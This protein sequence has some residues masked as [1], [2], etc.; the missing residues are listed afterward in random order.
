[1]ETTD[2]PQTR[3][4]YY[5]GLFITFGVI[6]AF[7]TSIV[8]YHLEMGSMRAKLDRQAEEIFEEK[9]LEL[10]KFF[11]GL[12]YI[13][14]AL[15]GSQLLV[16]YINSPN[17]ETYK[18]AVDLFKGVTLSNPGLMQARYLD[19]GGQERIRIDWVFGTERPVVIAEK[20]LQQ[21][22]HRYYF[23]EASK[24]LPQSFWYS[25]LDLNVENRII[26]V[27]YK[28]VLRIA[29]PI[30]VAQKFE[31][32][33]VINMH[34]KE[35]LNKLI[36]DPVFDI[37]LID[38]DGY[39]MRSHE[40]NRSWSRYLETGYTVEKMKP[41]IYKEILY[42]DHGVQLTRIGDLYI[43]SVNKFLES[44][45]ALLL[46][47]GKK[48]KMQSMQNERQKAAVLI[49]GVI[50][51]L[52]I[53]LA[54]LISKRPADMHRRIT[55]QN[56]ILTESMLLIDQNIHTGIMDNKG[57]FV[58]VSSAFAHTLGFPKEQFPGMP[59]QKIYAKN[60]P[61]EE[62]SEIWE[63]V[64]QGH[65]WS[66]E[67]QH[68]KKNGDSY[69]ADAVLVPKRDEANHV[70][71]VTVLFQ[72]ITDKKNIELLSN[73]DVM[74]G[75][76]NR[77]FFSTTIEKELRRAFRDSKSLSFAMLDVD[78]FKNYNDNYG[79]Q[80][81]DYVLREVAKVLESKMARGSDYCFRLGGEEF[82]LLFSDISPEDALRFVDKIRQAIFDQNIEHKWSAAADVVTVSIGLL[83]IIPSK[84]ASVDLI[85]RMA[86]EVLYVAKG[87]GKNCVVSKVYEGAA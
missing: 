38:G 26:E 57:L 63:T 22:G 24:I 82:G 55:N 40:E 50:F 37:C 9:L 86:D 73:T 23:T 48:D 8:N 1:M 10:G 7:C 11:G 65:T 81:G 75:L 29:T 15:S 4:L 14:T 39:F 77:R 45:R 69:W 52:S 28:P 62:Y 32:I 41:D 66:G 16:E 6:I 12:D 76:Y 61:Q 68:K 79:H 42:R 78:F 44:D 43:G 19:A 46:M 71:G 18:R 3:R 17:Q 70:S 20:E 31:G 85:Y 83:T 54:L 58:E 64:L 13:V 25:K 36:H 33:I 5:V 72:D 56:Q 30:Y 80:K 87:K 74:T 51:A 67:L 49:I 53:P 59:Y 21:K 27:P 2:I 34:A 60:L 47:H 35:F 84:G